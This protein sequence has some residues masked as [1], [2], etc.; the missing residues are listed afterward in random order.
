MDC[1]LKLG[2]GLAQNSFKSSSS[3]ELNWTH[4]LSLALAAIAS[5]LSSIDASFV[6]P[7]EDEIWIV[8]GIK[9]GI[10]LALN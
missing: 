10:G 2:M 7:F 3:E 5:S 6:S 1:V 4:C 9:S 8:E